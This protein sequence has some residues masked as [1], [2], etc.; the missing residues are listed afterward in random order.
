MRLPAPYNLQTAQ[1]APSVLALSDACS[2]TCSQVIRPP[3]KF[4]SS[5][6][7]C[8]LYS[9]HWIACFVSCMHTMPAPCKRLQVVLKSGGPS[10]QQMYADMSLWRIRGDTHPLARG[11][12]I[13]GWSMRKVGCKHWLSTYSPTSLSSSRAVDCGGRHSTFLSLHCQRKNKHLPKLNQN[14]ACLESLTHEGL[15]CWE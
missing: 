7:L 13:W 3:P 11:D 14:M 5:A 2:S 10:W 4:V 9:H 6:C 8:T 1:S 15:I 12:M